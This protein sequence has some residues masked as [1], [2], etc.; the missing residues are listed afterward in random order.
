MK[1]NNE[2]LNNQLIEEQRKNEQ[3]FSIQKA[4]DENE[5]SILGEIAHCLQ[6]AS[7]D[8]ILPKLSKKN[9]LKNSDNN[10]K[11]NENNNNKEKRFF[12]SF[13]NNIK[14]V[15]KKTECQEKK[16]LNLSKNMA[17]FKINNNKSTENPFLYYNMV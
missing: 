16:T 3:L 1:K 15:D 13:R 5:N 2:I 9:Q 11:N 7:F 6:V 4:K 14:L 10:L 8:E 17:L 12:H